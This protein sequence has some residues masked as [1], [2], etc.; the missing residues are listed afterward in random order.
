MKGT[1]SGPWIGGAAF[2]AVIIML[3]AWFLVISP[4]VDTTSDTKA[5]T[6]DT[7]LQNDILRSAIETL[8]KDSANLPTYQTNLAGL[9]AKL[10]TTIASA[11]FRGE[12]GQLATAHSVTVTI[13]N[14]IAPSTVLVPVAVATPD[15]AASP[16]ATPSDGTTPSATASDG[17]APAT[18]TTSAAPAAGSPA[19]EGFAYVQI[20][21]A[22]LGSYDNTQAFLHDL[23]FATTRSFLVTA[24][25]SVQQ[26][27]QEANGGRPKTSVGDVE[28]TITGNIFVL[29][30]EY[31]PVTPSAPSTT[32][33]VLP[34]PGSPRNPYVPVGP[35]N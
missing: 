16:A 27:D 31:T 1:K 6:A 24:L 22:V 29:K 13:L 2:A 10:P 20:T 32:A 28:L 9:Q 26:T 18:D 11:A 5:Q 17:T 34:A 19:I 30:D 25:S 3:G 12:L 14:E 33:P 15:A 21:L 4:V 35:T 23:Q 8:K 7:K